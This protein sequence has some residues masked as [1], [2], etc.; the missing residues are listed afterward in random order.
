MAR[1]IRILVA[2]LDDDRGGAQLVA[3]ALADAGT[4]VVYAGRQ[5]SAEMIAAAAIQE[6]VDAIGLASVDGALAT[7]VL[8]ALTARG[9]HEV[10]VKRFASDEGRDAIVA[11]VEG[12]VR[13]RVVAR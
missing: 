2:E 13:P 8:D 1:T 3:R 5:Q 4:E 12:D 7:A 10:I 6:A 9:A 11:W